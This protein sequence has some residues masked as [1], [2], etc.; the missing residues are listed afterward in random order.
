MP[1]FGDP[2]ARLLVIGLSPTV[3]GSNRTGRIFTGDIS[4]DLLFS[5]L[6]RAGFANHPTSRE[7]GDGNLLTDVYISSI[8]RCAAPHN[9]PLLAELD[10]CQAFLHEELKLLDRL[11]GIITLGHSAFDR[12]LTV[13][14]ARGADIPPIKFAH[15]LLLQ[16]GHG[17]PWIL[18][19]YHPS[20]KNTQIDH[21]NRER[22]DAIWQT[23]RRLLDRG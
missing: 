20:P 11:Q 14:R 22:L 6:H 4:A 23:S 15:G 21:L 18:C 13:L 12:M 9:R 1:G 17:F 8:G 5:N 2:F 16:P 19:S 3:S 10:A 7:F